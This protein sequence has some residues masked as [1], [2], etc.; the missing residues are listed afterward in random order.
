[1]KYA[2]TS[3][4]ARDW[5]ML[6]DFYIEVFGC[7]ELLPRRD[8]QG[9]WIEEGTGVVGARIQGVHLLLPGHSQGGPTLEIFQ[10]NSSLSEPKRIN[11]EG[12]AHLAFQVDDVEITL[13]AVIDAGGG[14]L[15]GVVRHQ[16]PGVGPITFV[17]ATDPEGNFVE[18][19]K[20]E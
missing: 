7:D 11:R 4:V 2:H 17:Y 6:A 19:Q 20:R 10:Y 14:K 3:I 8:L 16:I 13:Q 15:S 12:L 18:L 1:M 5:R 9:A